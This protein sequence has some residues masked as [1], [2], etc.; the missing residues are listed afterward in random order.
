MAEQHSVRVG[1]WHELRWT[2][3]PPDNLRIVQT[4]GFAVDKVFV[5]SRTDAG[6]FLTGVTEWV[7]DTVHGSAPQSRPDKAF[8]DPDVLVDLAAKSG[9]VSAVVL[10]T[11]EYRESM[12][13]M[14]QTIHQAYHQD[15]GGTWQGCQRNTCTHAAEVLGVRGDRP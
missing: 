9:E 2:K 5:I 6:E 12:R 13:W 15:V 7:V 14:A 3:G 11:A 10:A 4:D 1:R 8:L